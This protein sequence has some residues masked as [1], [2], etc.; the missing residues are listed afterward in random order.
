M[1]KRKIETPVIQSLICSVRVMLCY[2]KGEKNPTVIL[3]K[4]EKIPHEL[5]AD[6]LA[7]AVTIAQDAIK[8]QSKIN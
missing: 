1:S 3:E 6:M 5:V 2:V 4:P 8:T 7:A